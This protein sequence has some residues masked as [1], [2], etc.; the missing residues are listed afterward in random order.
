MAV[1][2]FGHAASHGEHSTRQDL[3]LRGR[4]EF[5]PAESR[6]KW[7]YSWLC[8][9]PAL[10]ATRTTIKKFDLVAQAMNATSAAIAADDL[11]LTFVERRGGQVRNQPSRDTNLQLLSMCLAIMGVGGQAATVEP[12]SRV[13]TVQAVVPKPTSTELHQLC[14]LG[15]PL[16]PHT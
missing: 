11:I 3:S 9:E 8:S 5:S 12:K 2:L 15:Q 6:A 7:T 13:G 1:A 16:R 14:R 10:N 4:S